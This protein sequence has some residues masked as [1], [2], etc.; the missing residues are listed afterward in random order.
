MTLLVYYHGRFTSFTT[1]EPELIEAVR[2]IYSDL[3]EMTV[4]VNGEPKSDLP[5]GFKLLQEKLDQVQCTQNPSPVVRQG[6]QCRDTA[7]FIFTSG[8][9][10]ITL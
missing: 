9:T 1:S 4:Y 10:G 3:R 5:L 6:Q 7:V 2:L 8:T